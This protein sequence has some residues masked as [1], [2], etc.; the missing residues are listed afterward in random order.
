MSKPRFVVDALTVGGIGPVD[1]AVNGGGCVGLSAPSGAGKTRLLRAMADLDAHAG[2][3]RLDGVRATDMPAPEWRRQVAFLAA[4]SAWWADTPRAHFDRDCVSL[5]AALDLEP[6]LLDTPIGHLSSGQR[7]RMALVRTLAHIPAVLLLDEPT[8]NLDG[9]NIERVER[10]IGDY[11]NTHDA[12]C[13]WVSHD[14]AQ[15][16]RVAS[17]RLVLDARGQPVSTPCN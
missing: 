4:E 10:L 17:S 11:R 12:C 3:C 5:L 8:A 1:I 6:D 9:V 16:A 13:I 14:E 7:Q 15:L 2:E